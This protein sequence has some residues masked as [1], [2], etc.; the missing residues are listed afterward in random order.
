MPASSM[1]VVLLGDSARA[2][3]VNIEK[4][5]EGDQKLQGT[6]LNLTVSINL[7]SKPGMYI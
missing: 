1:V 2:L 4:Q 7:R 3:L 5:K 6:R